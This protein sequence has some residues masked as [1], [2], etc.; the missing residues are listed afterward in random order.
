MGKIIFALANL[1]SQFTWAKRCL[2][3][4]SM[5]NFIIAWA[6]PG[7]IYYCIGKSIIA[8]ANVF[9]MGNLFCM[10]KIILRTQRR[11]LSQTQCT[12]FHAHNFALAHHKVRTHLANFTALRVAIVSV[13]GIA[14]NVIHFFYMSSF[15]HILHTRTC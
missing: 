4:H 14:R 13:S 12:D 1:L 8:L 6:N 10:G 15:S 11:T 9:S 3:G 7:Q 2:H 5:G